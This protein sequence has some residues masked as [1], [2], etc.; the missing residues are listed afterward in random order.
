MPHQIEIAF[1]KMNK[2][3]WLRIVVP[4]TTPGGMTAN[5]LKPGGE[6]L[7]TMNL[8]TGNNL[9]DISSIN[10]QVISVRVD[11][12]YETLLKEVILF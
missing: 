3:N 11:T 8:E 7:K 4:Y 12:P 9:I 2:G 1:E 6:L 10:H 5:L